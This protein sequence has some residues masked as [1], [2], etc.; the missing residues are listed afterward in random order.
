MSL[1]GSQL[2]P[3]TTM[4]MTGKRVFTLTLTLSPDLRRTKLL[5]PHRQVSPVE[6]MYAPCLLLRQLLLP[7]FQVHLL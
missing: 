4:A 2:Q 1:G 5:Q 6:R 7:P 3:T